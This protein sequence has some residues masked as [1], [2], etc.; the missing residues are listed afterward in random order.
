MPPAVLPTG[1]RRLTVS[2][3]YRRPL[4]LGSLPDGLRF[5]ECGRQLIDSDLMLPP[6]PPR[7]LLPSTPLGL[8]LSDRYFHPLLPGVI[9]CSV[10][11]LRLSSAYR[12][13]GIEVV[14]PTDAEVVWFE[15]RGRLNL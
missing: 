4:Q 9:P 1:L 15:K 10:R 7:V 13:E 2:N 14:L 5:L 12:D 6:L 11:W 3:R 8:D